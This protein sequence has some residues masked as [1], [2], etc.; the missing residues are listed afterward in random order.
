MTGG[1]PGDFSQ[2][3]T[4]TWFMPF[5]AVCTGFARCAHRGGKE[6]FA[7]MINDQLELSS[8]ERLLLHAAVLL[9]RPFPGKEYR[10]QVPLIRMI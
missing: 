6:V 10:D 3:R 4:Y 8:V 5:P 1:Q 7:W 9:D 2:S